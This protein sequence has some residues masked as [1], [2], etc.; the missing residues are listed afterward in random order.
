MK[1]CIVI[2]DSFKGTL[3]SHEIC[4]IAREEIPQTFPDCRIVTIPVADGGEGTVDCFLEACGG[5][6]ITL[7]V[8]GPLGELRE[9]A[10]GVLPDGTAV[11]EMAAAAGLPLVPEERKNPCETTTY[12]VGQQ[13]RHAVEH[14]ARRVVLGLGGSATNDGG[15]GAAA[16]MGV[17]FLDSSGR[18]FIPVGGTLDRIADADISA[19]QQLLSGVEL[20]VMCDID[21][22][23]YG[24]QGAAAI[25]GP[26]KGADAAMV[27][28]LDNQLRALDCLMR[29]KLGKD[30]AHVNGAGAAGGFGAGCLAFLGGTLKSGIDIV[31]ETVNFERHLIGADVVITGEG[32]IDGQS[33]RGKVVCGVAK[34]SKAHGVP[35]LVIAGD[36]APDAKAAYQLGVSA[37]FSTNRRPMA[38]ADAKEFSHENYRAVLRDVLCCIRAAEGFTR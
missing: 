16:A 32:R 25:F 24:P 21:N 9:A 22:P 2:S 35:V 33:L 1:K 34:A 19:A 37:M 12:G 38:F 18:A 26:Q 11:V 30:V 15:C 17:R 28:F 36:I 10:Y 8:T 14:G 29:N 5:Q 3:S 23:L 13:L 4:A 31:K 20:I 7:P 6:R 27:T